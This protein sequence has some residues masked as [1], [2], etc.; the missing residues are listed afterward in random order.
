MKVF[1]WNDEKNELLKKTRSVSF[2]AVV[3]AIQQGDLLAA[4]KHP[5]SAKYANQVVLYVEIEDYVYTVPCVE[6][7]NE[8]FLKTA[9]RDRK[10][11]KIYLN[12]G[13]DNEETR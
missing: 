8:I 1:T 11:T 5:N 3:W 2:E 13:D 9:Y 12:R 10:A 7:E 4:I 6:N